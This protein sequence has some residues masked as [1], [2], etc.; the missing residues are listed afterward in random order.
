MTDTAAIKRSTA[1]MT[2]RYALALTMIAILVG[3]GYASFEQ[4]IEEQATSGAVVNIS[5]RQRMLSQRTAYF[6]RTMLAAGT[7]QEYALAG[8]KMRQAANLLELSHK[9]LI[10]GSDVL[11]LPRA[12]SP[13]VRRMYFEGPESLDRMM[14]DYIAALR[15]IQK[16]PWG[17]LTQDLPAVREVLESA[18]GPLLD[19]L[20]LMVWQYQREGEETVH[21]LR[22]LE[23][24]VLGLT[25]LTLALE[26]FLIFR[27]M[28]SHVREQIG[29]VS[30]ISDELRAARDTLE[31]QVRERTSELHEAKEAAEQANQAKSRFLAAASHDLLQ[32]LEAIGMFT[33]ML[34]REIADERPRAIF[35]DLK[36]AQRSM[37]RLL[38]SLLEISKLEAGV[39]VPRPR[40]M[41]I[42]PLLQ[43][44][45]NEF[46]PQALHRGLTV[47]VVGRDLLVRSDPALLERIVRNFMGNAVRY[48]REGGI[49]LGCRKRGDTLRIEVYDTGP[50]IPEAERNR[51][52]EEFSQLDDPN[53]DRSEGIG[54]GL[55]I[56]DR[57]ARLLGHDLDVRSTVG[58]GSVFAIEVPLAEEAA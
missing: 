54:L 42:G 37:R 53:R 4:V 36:L 32:P 23:A 58:R 46:L 57:L 39:V 35:R 24:T 21:T 27:P 48:T 50:G 2:R 43:Q 14:Q 28:V 15:A 51:I 16:T 40:P 1:W 20:D 6:V 3:M 44:M 30:R 18:P 31:E 56:C 38:D 29:E 13:T 47:R 45:G 17:R 52:F 55:A 19:A 5:G 25:L 9:G 12:M 7:E 34:E 26:A 8:T 33:G 22:R 41:R 49:L 11:G 10:E